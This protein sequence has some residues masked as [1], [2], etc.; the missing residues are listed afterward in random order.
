MPA[1]DD[2]VD[3]IVNNAAN[4]NE[5]LRLRAICPVPKYRNAT[6]ADAHLAREGALWEAAARPGTGLLVHREMRV[7]EIATGIVR[8]IPASAQRPDAVG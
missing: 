5:L 4:G 2:A 3:D 6:I 8:E 7:V 1:P